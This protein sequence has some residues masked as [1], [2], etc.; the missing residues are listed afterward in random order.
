MYPEV[1]RGG[2]G[3]DFWVRGTACPILEGISCNSPGWCLVPITM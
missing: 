2:A 1:G 3:Y